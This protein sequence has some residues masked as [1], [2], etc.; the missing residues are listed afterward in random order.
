MPDRE[1]F[2]NVMAT[3]APDYVKGL[4][5]HANLQRHAAGGKNT[6]DKTIVISENW[7]GA[8]QA[9]PFISQHRGSTIHLL[10][11]GSKKVPQ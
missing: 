8:L 2:F 11:A 9:I 7:M 4:V 1:Y 3:H 10:K 5:E 6:E